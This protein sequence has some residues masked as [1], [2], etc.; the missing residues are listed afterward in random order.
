V[1]QRGPAVVCGASM[2][3]LLTAR[4]L[5][6]FYE[7]VTVVER[8]VL[9]ENTTQRRGVPQGRHL[10]MMLSR[11]SCILAELFPGL[12]DDLAA[13]GAPVLDG[14]D[15]S[16]FYVR[17]GE[18]V[19]CRSG[20]FA[21]P[22]AI[23]MQLASRPLLETHIRRRVRA[24]ENVTAL[25]GHDVVE[26]IMAVDRVSAVRVV[27]R[28]SGQESVLDADWQS[29][30]QGDR[31]AHRRSSRRTAMGG[32][33]AELRGE[34]E[35]LESFLSNAARRDRR[36]GRGDRTY[37]PTLNRGRLVGLRER[38][39]DPHADRRRRTAL[40][41][42]QLLDPATNLFRPSL[43]MRVITGNR[44]NLQVRPPSAVS[45]HRARQGRP[46]RR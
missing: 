2:G 12:I 19:L 17:V 7:S 15:P 23:T 8:D 26:P 25:D 35:L 5:A 36:E 28:E 46:R 32:R 39:D 38:H 45:A 14:T 30:R 24:I 34:F 43:L 33:R 4:V 9:P 16:Q 18:H 44:W 11:G 41:V 29:M 40:R 27:E 31:P 20:E 3:G 37:P 22:D 1:P 21:N 42:L 13:A 6:D 10:H